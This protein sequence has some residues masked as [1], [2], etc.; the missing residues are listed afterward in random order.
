MAKLTP[1]NT[2]TSVEAQKMITLEMVRDNWKA[3]YA[4]ERL[5][6]LYAT[7][8]TPIEVLTLREGPWADVPDADRIWTLTRPNAIPEKIQ[9]LFAAECAAEACRVANWTD[10]RSLAAIQAARDFAEGKITAGELAAAAAAASA[11][12]RATARAA[13][14]VADA[15]ACNASRASRAS[16]ASDAADAAARASDAADAAARAARAADAAAR[17][18]DAAARAARAAAYNASRA[19][20]ASRA[21]QIQIMLTLLG[22]G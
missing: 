9:R 16:R 13:A 8:K 3:C 22:K 5:A 2:R 17:A 10:P 18:A 19:S 21:S 20:R 15:A 11:T 12:A 14:D 7:P 6:L 1:S 4:G